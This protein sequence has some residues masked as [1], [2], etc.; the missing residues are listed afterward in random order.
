MRIDAREILARWDFL[1]L[2]EADQRHL[3]D[4]HRLIE[5]D[6][7]AII[8]E[9]YDALLRVEPIAEFLAE[10]QMQERLRETQ[11]LY[12]LTLGQRSDQLD[13]FED[14]LRIGVAHER[15]GLEQ[16]WYLGAYAIL[17]GILARRL[18][19]EHA[20]DPKALAESLIT[21][22]K[23]VTVDA[24]LAVET[25]YH[26][27]MRR[28]E[29]SL[30]QLT[31]TQKSLEE[32]ARLDGL[33]RVNNRMYLMTCLENEMQRSQRFRRPFTLLFLDIDH[34]KVI[35]DAFG[36]SAGDSVLK[37]VVQAVR[38]V[39]RPVDLI[40]R[41][42]G[43][44]FLVGLVETDEATARQVAERI[45]LKVAHTPFRS[46]SSQVALTVSIG[47][48]SLA[49]STER[50]EDLVNRADHALYQAK[51]AGRD[52]VRVFEEDIAQLNPTH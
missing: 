29:D 42:G 23:I 20:N 40:G 13:Y 18:R 10:P 43:E 48:A 47:L 5:E 30:R 26:A 14:R 7:A 6:A 34:F 45:R 46:D 19:Q 50:V 28:L 25:Y 38:S 21:L 24:T 31:A 32:L 44:E 52:Q 51:Q 1:A 17:F 49:S 15:V 4:I 2:S 9:F 11:R 3:D 22:Q 35:N 41:F 16:K 33:T 37:Q 12:L 27:T 8:G 39:I 36:H